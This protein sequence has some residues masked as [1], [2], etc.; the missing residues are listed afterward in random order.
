MKLLPMFT[1]FVKDGSKAVK[2]ISQQEF[3]EVPDETLTELL[4][5]PT[6]VVTMYAMRREGEYDVLHVWCAHRKEVALRTHCGA[7]SSKVH[8]E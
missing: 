8:Q 3:K 7:L 2:R 4:D 1:S 5:I 6:M